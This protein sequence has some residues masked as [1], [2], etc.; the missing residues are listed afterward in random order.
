MA[1]VQLPE[2][3]KTRRGRLTRARLHAGWS[4]IGQRI[5]RSK[6]WRGVGV[7]LLLLLLGAA[8]A[9]SYA[10]QLLIGLPSIAGLDSGNLRADTLI[11]DRNGAVLADVGQQGDHRLVVGLHEVSPFVLQATIAIEDRTFYNNPGVDWLGVLRA[12]LSNQSAGRL[13][14]GASTITQQLARSLFLTPDRSYERKLKEVILAYQLTQTYSKDQI[15]ELY[16]NTNF[17]GAQSYGV[18]AASRTY[19][20]KD[21]KK[22]DLA[23][24]AVIAGLPS[25]PTQWNPLLHPEASKTRQQEVLDAM[26]RVG[27][28]SPLE[29]DA[30]LAE[31]LTFYSPQ[32]SFLA[33]HFVDYVQEELLQLGFKPGQQQ[34]LVKT[35]LD[36]GMQRIGEQ[37]LT[38]NLAGN[39][40]R[41]RGGQLGSAMVAM[42]PK[43]GYI[44]VMV[45]S[46]DYNANGG[47]INLSTVPRNPGS[48]LKPY[49]YGAVFNARRATVETPV[50][51]GPN[52]LEI[53]QVIGP[54]YKV[55]NYDHKIHGTFP[56][57]QALGNS[58]NICAVKVE[59]SIGVPAVLEY[60]R[61]LGVFPR[62]P[63][64]N[65]G[66]DAMAPLTNYG[67]ALTLGGYPVTLLEHVTAL[68]VYANMGVYHS[69]ESILTV[70]DVHGKVLYRANPDS[71]RRQ[72]IQPGLAYIMSDV[73]STDANRAAIFGLRS[74]LHLPD[75]TA[76]AKTGTSD[77]FK[78][79]LTIGYTPDIAVVMWVG[80][81]LGITH[82]MIPGSD[83]VFVVAP[84]WHRFMEAALSGVPD[85]W[86][87]PP[88]DII[89]NNGD[90]YLS[91]YVTTGRLPNDNPLPTPSPSPVYIV[92]PDPGTGPVLASPTPTPAPSPSP[93]P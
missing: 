86:Y 65:G 72:A 33:P 10:Q 50:V 25:A 14:S 23:E 21:V 51:D 26:L 84:A 81:I 45:G 37:V 93:H 73:L 77:D 59:L 24:A 66:Y 43:T 74:P 80:D 39:T 17:Y 3:I 15:L 9:D 20:Q 12:A 78:D 30:A 48:S 28:I 90:W 18:Q 32:N 52:P 4:P 68:S 67:P 34:L 58:L 60:M 76:A 82:T 75:R 7:L 2:Q 47:Q 46:T 87:T 61:N 89:W 70:S 6:F 53:P 69:A 88:P 31:K 38:E 19:F 16:L 63:L 62:V 5:A 79:A 11:M 35:T 40:W 27:M 1:K 29:H 41:D 85:K 92:P 13:V 71:S 57:K 36:L 8:V 64:P 49:T 44:L 42:D 55:Y 22:L 56:L 91:D 54:V 83:G